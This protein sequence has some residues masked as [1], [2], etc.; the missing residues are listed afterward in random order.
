MA[1]SRGSYGLCAII[2]SLA[3]V[4]HHSQYPG[5]EANEAEYRAAVESLATATETFASPSTAIVRRRSEASPKVCAH[6]PGGAS[7]LSFLRESLPP[8]GAVAKL[9]GLKA[10]GRIAAVLKGFARAALAGSPPLPGQP[11]QNR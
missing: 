4:A 3:E 7:P 1:E 10:S 11:S 6:G 2:L 5:S 8:R 9:A